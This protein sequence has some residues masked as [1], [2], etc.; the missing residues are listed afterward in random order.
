M[1][2]IVSEMF[3]NIPPNLPYGPV[4]RATF[5]AGSFEERTSIERRG[6]KSVA[7]FL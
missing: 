4:S 6:V 1:T 5:V 3:N 7:Y 2:R